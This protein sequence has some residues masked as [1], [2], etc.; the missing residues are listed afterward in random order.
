MCVY[1]CTFISRQRS[2]QDTCSFEKKKKKERTDDVKSP[3]RYPNPLPN[4]NTTS[5]GANNSP[6][7]RTAVDES[8]PVEMKLYMRHPRNSLAIVI[9]SF[10]LIL[11]LRE[12]K[13]SV[14][15]SILDFFFI[16]CMWDFVFWGISIY[17]ICG[18]FFFPFCVWRGLLC[19]GC[20]HSC[21]IWGVSRG[22]S[23]YMIFDGIRLSLLLLPPPTQQSN[24]KSEE[25]RVLYTVGWDSKFQVSLSFFGK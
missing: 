10:Q 6:N 8:T 18:C 12:K 5:L 7:V 19:W 3:A 1:E 2:V 22:G 25:N 17:K 4:A 13:M 23:Y 20:I 11:L 24:K 21:V 14:S 9:L 16:W 15:I